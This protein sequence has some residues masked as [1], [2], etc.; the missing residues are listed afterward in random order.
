MADISAERCVLVG[1]LNR[2]VLGAVGVDKN[3]G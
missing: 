2:A 1:S 3:H